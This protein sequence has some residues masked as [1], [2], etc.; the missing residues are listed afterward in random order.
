MEI[1]PDGIFM[2]AKITGDFGTK[3]FFLTLESSFTGN[4]STL[5]FLPATIIPNLAK[6]VEFQKSSNSDQFDLCIYDR[7]IYRKKGIL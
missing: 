5:Q 7:Y 6:K 4:E 3:D 1:V 2:K